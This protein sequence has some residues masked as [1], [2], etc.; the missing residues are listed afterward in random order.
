LI[1]AI[2]DYLV[3]KLKRGKYSNRKLDEVKAILLTNDL[4]LQPGSIIFFH[5]RNS[6]ISWIICYYSNSI[7]SHT[8][9]ISFDNKIIDATTAGVIEHPLID[10]A[11][12]NT[13]YEAWK[14][15]NIPNNDIEKMIFKMREEHLGLPY[16]WLKV[17]NLFI[18]TIF[19]IKKDAFRLRYLIDFS[20]LLLILYFIINLY[21]LKVIL[22]IIIGL[23]WF[24][25]IKNI[26]IYQ[27]FNIRF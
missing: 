1:F 4:F 26:I 9:I 17:F 24:I 15:K 7:W 13:Y 14:L 5:T 2:Y 23:Y 12:G 20:V 6:F 16:G 18:I 27:K 8:G 21:I 19:A 11:D 22:A 25:V 3:Y 10:Y